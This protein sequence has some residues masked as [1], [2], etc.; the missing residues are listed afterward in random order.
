[1]VWI[2]T[3]V[4]IYSISIISTGTIVEIAENTDE[5]PLECIADE[6]HPRLS[7]NIEV[8]S[9]EIEYIYNNLTETTIQGHV[10]IDFTIKQSMTQL[11][12]HAK[13]LIKL[14]EPV[15]STDGRNHSVTMRLYPP[16]DYVSLYFSS[17]DSVFA[18]GRYELKQ[19]FVV[20]LVDG[21]VGFYQNSYKDK[22]GTIGYRWI[23]LREKKT[24][25]VDWW[26][27]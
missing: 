16:N 4:L 12:Y 21:N 2:V 1:M 26:D 18:P 24:E 6:C 23:C 5:D 14:D 11:V 15:L 25:R 20:S 3:G 10:T 9:Y 7:S 19:G 22:N 8:Y 27:F 17:N 13:R